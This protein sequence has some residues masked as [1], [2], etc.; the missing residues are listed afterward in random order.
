M[1]INIKLCGMSRLILLLLMI[2]L[3]ITACTSP[4]EKAE[5]LQQKAV[6]AAKKGDS[7]AFKPLLS[8][9]QVISTGDVGKV[10]HALLLEYDIAKVEGESVDQR[11]TKLKDSYDGKL[12]IFDMLLSDQGIPKAAKEAQINDGMNAFDIISSLVFQ[13]LNHS[14][15][16]SQAAHAFYLKVN[17]KLWKTTA[18]IEKKGYRG[19]M[20]NVKAADTM[21]VNY[22][23]A[24]ASKQK[25]ENY[26]RDTKLSQI[27]PQHKQYAQA[28]SSADN[29]REQGDVVGAMSSFSKVKRDYDELYSA[30]HDAMS[31]LDKYSGKQREWTSF[32]NRYSSYLRN[33]PSDAQ[34]KSYQTAADQI[35]AT[36]DID[37]GKAKYLGRC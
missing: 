24:L 10:M 36:G 11:L 8:E 3:H 28:F 15:K 34:A 9:M 20:S 25:W 18:G 32:K 30:S 5:K 2:G 1:R 22:E 19:L 37:G 21:H 23:S 33:P 4:E 16:S 27:L 14:A 35:L 13:T 7:V 29:Q 12:A 31:A 17:E 26:G 6:A